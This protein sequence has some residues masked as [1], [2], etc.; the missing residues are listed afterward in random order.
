MKKNLLRLMSFV[1]ALFGVLAV[2]MIIVQTVAADNLA[3]AAKNKAN[4]QNFS[5]AGRGAILDVRGRELAASDKKGTRH[6][7]FA[8]AA[9]FITGYAGKDIGSSAVERYAAD[10]LRGAA[11]ETYAVGPIGRLFE[12]D[13]GSDV[14]LTI[15]AELQKV[16]YDALAGKRG[17]VIAMDAKNGA[18]LALVSRPAFDPETVEKN[19][20]T[21]LNDGDNPLL[22]RAL[23]GLYP[24]GSTIKP[25][26]ADAALAMN[27]TDGHEVFDC[28]GVLDVGGGHSIRE[29]HGEIHGR[30]KLGDALKESCNVT[31]GSLAMRMGA[32]ELKKTFERFGFDK[33]FNEEIVAEKTHLPDF[34][35]LD[36]GDIAQVGIG[37]SYLMTTP[38][39]MM[40]LAAAMANGGVVMKPYI[41]DRVIDPAG[42]TVK[43]AEPKIFFK[44]TDKD[45]ADTINGWMTAVVEDGTGKAAK[46]DGI[47]TAGK[48]GTA[49]NP[50][51]DDHA[52]FIGSVQKGGRCVAFAIIVENGGNGGDVA[53]PIAKKIIAAL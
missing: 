42:K 43:K 50:Q 17:A 36:S 8:E 46:I 33:N 3:T 5:S 28:N 13:A 39:S 14:Y 34:S 53:A 51:G 23:D 32:A 7:P 29:S 16:A 25:M 2:G 10:Y 41:I 9:A 31:F 24:P 12:A 45:R 35:S 11:P 52:W 15:D 48:T 19:W 4:A 49:E 30:L 47:K 38:F 44:A 26:I 20:Q 22:N 21:L 18:V 1:L 37:Q 27:A 40:L 6:Y